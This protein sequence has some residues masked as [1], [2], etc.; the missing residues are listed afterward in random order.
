MIGFCRTCILIRL[1]KIMN[2]FYHSR[3]VE[4]R[5]IS[6]ASILV[7]IFAKSNCIVR[8]LL[9]SKSI[10][11]IFVKFL[12]S[13]AHNALR[14]SGTRWYKNGG[15][16]ESLLCITVEQKINKIT[17]PFFWYQAEGTGP[18]NDGIRRVWS[19]TRLSFKLLIFCNRL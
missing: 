19:I 1:T 7:R 3:D 6:H 13:L 8:F 17:G 2:N 14:M 12:I 10:V 4:S 5:H 15:T 11:R 18:L 16:S 9:R